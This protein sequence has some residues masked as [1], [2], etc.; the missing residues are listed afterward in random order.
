MPA[1]LAMG[2]LQA[3]APATEAPAAA[4]KPAQD[5]TALAKLQR[6][7]DN[8][9][10]QITNLKRARHDGGGNHSGGRGGQRS[11]G[12]YRQD[13]G[14]GGGG[15]GGGNRQND[16]APV[17]QQCASD[18]CRDFNFKRDGCTYG[19]KCRH[20][21]ICAKCGQNHPFAGSSCSQ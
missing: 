2:V 1:L 7:Y 19:A 16:G 14:G 11:N 21:H 3:E 8:Q 10:A 18:V 12:N 15:G 13:G 4:G 20:K 9:A 6:A 17:R 5:A